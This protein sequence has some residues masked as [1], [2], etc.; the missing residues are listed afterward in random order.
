MRKVALFVSA[1]LIGTSLLES[2]KEEE[3]TVTEAAEHYYGYLVKGD[4]DH[5]LQGLADYDSLPEDYRSQLRDMHLQ[6]L[7]NE[8][9]VRGGLASVKSLRDTLV[10]DSHAFVFLEVAY[11]D[12]TREQIS[13]PLVLTAKGWRLR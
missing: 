8:K 7:E 3:R 2:C 12:S 11:G 6:F 13:L 4:V 10:D 9:K 5:Y 1:L